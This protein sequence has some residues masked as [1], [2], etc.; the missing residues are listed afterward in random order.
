MLIIQA[1]LRLW[2]LLT[3]RLETH[4]AESVGLARHSPKVLDLGHIVITEA[5][6]SL[7]QLELLIDYGGVF[8]SVVGTF[9]T[10]INY[11]SIL[12]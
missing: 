2:L 3:R 10:Q 4:T 9:I 5:I 11:R 6:P 7:P 12:I 8:S 1:K